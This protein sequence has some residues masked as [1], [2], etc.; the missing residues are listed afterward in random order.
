MGSSKMSLKRLKNNIGYEIYVVFKEVSEYCN[1]VKWII[2][3]CAT[4]ATSSTNLSMT[5]LN[6]KLFECIADWNLG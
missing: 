1:I 3:T 5:Q 6:Q 4:C 2:A